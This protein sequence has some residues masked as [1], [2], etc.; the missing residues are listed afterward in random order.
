MSQ[1][2]TTSRNDALDAG[3]RPG[4]ETARPSGGGRRR[5][6]FR[7]WVGLTIAVALY[8][9]LADPFALDRELPQSYVAYSV[10]PLM[11]LLLGL[12]LAWLASFVWREPRG[13]KRP[14]RGSRA[15]K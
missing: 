15:A 3:P 4:S 11:I 13:A 14:S 12:S 10:P 2:R 7:A 9:G 8:V 6:L 1:S 5:W